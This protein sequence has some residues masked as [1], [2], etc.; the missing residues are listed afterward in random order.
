MVFF[1]KDFIQHLMMFGEIVQVV[2]PATNDRVQSYR[3]ELTLPSLMLDL[4][5]MSVSSVP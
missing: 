4:N 1:L 2:V 5:G 3:S